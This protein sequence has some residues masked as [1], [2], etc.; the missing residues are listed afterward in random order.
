M[1]KHFRPPIGK[2]QRRIWR[3]FLVR[4]PDALLTTTEIV[5]LAYPCIRDGFRNHLYAVAVSKCPLRASLER[6]AR[7]YST[8]G[9]PGKQAPH[10]SFI[11]CA[12]FFG[13]SAAPSARA[14]V[15][16]RRGGG[17]LFVPNRCAVLLTY[18]WTNPLMQG[19]SGRP[20]RFEIRHRLLRLAA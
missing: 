10:G 5:R 11:L 18:T 6:S 1:M 20:P 4:S 17:V 8:F 2:L 14:L 9:K 16:S 7:A 3:A 15:L 12:C 19:S 13:H